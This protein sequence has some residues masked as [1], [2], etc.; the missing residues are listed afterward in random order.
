MGFRD[1]HAFNLAMLAKQAWRLVIGT[2]SLFY[3]VYKAR[4]FPRCSFMEA[5]LGYNPSFVWQ[6]LL[7]TR[8]LIREGSG[9]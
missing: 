1:F 4:Y 5:E 2:H 3:R 9:G 6:S 7:A 8:D